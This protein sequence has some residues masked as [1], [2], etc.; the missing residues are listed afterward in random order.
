MNDT[1]DWKL[2][3]RRAIVQRL[4]YA[5]KAAE[6][7]PVVVLVSGPAGVG[8]TVV[9]EQAFSDQSIGLYG[10]GKAESVGKGMFSAVVQ[11][12]ANAVTPWLQRASEPELELMRSHLVGFEDVIGSL[13]PSLG[14]ALGS[15]NDSEILLAEHRNRVYYALRALV[16]AVCQLSP[17]CVLV[18]DGFQRLDDETV[19]CLEWGL[20]DPELGGVLA[21]L[22][23]R[24]DATGLE[25]ALEVLKLLEAA[26]VEVHHFEMHP[27]TLKEVTQVVGG[28]SCVNASQVARISA[29]LFSQSSGS[30]R[31][32]HHAIELMGKKGLGEPDGWV[33]PD[34]LVGL[35]SHQLEAFGPDEREILGLVAC[36]EQPLL[37]ALLKRLVDKHFSQVNLEQLLERGVTSGLLLSTLGESPAVQLVNDC[38]QELCAGSPTCWPARNLL[39]VEAAL[40]EFR[41]LG[42]L[43][44]EPLFWLC[45]RALAASSLLTHHPDRLRV[46]GLAVVTSRR[47]RALAASDACRRAAGLAQRLLNWSDPAHISVEVH[48]EH[49]ISAWLAGDAENFEALAVEA[50]KIAT[51]LELI[52]VMELRLQAAI[53]KGEMTRR[54]RFGSEGVAPTVSVFA[55]ADGQCDC[56]N[57]FG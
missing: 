3:S 21:V 13:I 28:L 49:A 22:C 12:L 23:C 16:V 26:G 39:I 30:P 5:K 6:S 42:G 2:A 25:R 7:K 20:S 27:L 11:A 53:A 10:L 33:G 31:Y 14:L 19:R 57:R 38:L 56:L 15:L 52:P 45:D 18:L 35:L 50:E 43:S 4:L 8:K 32:L 54:S 41:A 37:V 9:V 51:P 34:Y 1:Q 48:I 24:S 46:V 36:A 40:E 29:Q 17:P 44:D 47:A 55:R